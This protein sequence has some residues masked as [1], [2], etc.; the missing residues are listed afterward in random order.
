MCVRIEFLQLILF[1]EWKFILGS[2]KCDFD[3]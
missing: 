3:S 1:Y 2:F